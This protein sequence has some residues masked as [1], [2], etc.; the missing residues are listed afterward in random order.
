MKYS[1]QKTENSEL[2]VKSTARDSKQ[3]YEL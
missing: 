3:D 2:A 1:F